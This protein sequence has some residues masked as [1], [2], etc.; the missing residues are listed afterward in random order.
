MTQAPL[1]SAVI[2]T[3]FRPHLVCRA[4]RSA[5]AQTMANLEV[6]V[7]VDGPDPETVAALKE[8]HDERLRVIALECNEGGSEARNIAVRQAH[9]EWIALLDDDDEWYPTKVEKQLA[10]AE[11]M[12]K[13]RTVVTCQ[14][15]DFQGSSN[16]LRPRRFPK[17]N[18][19]ISDFL[20]SEVSLLG[21]IEG[22]PQTST[23]LVSREFLLEVPFAKGLK[24]NQD[25][26]WLL[27]AL[28]LPDVS[29]ALVD[30][31][32][33]IFY[34]EKKRVRI[35]Q[36]LDWRDS[37]QW[38]MGNRNLFTPRALSSFL[39]VMCMNHAGKHGIQ[40]GVFCTLLKDCRRYGR[41]T[42]KVLWLLVLY[43]LVYPKMRA[44]ISSERRTALLY[45]SSAPGA[46]G[47]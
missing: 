27:R 45:H 19:A 7:V 46:S 16:L 38:A 22:F 37:Y 5:L 42:P 20:Y 44:F 10:V 26:D 6:I 34:N 13:G 30:E 9:S 33:S 17:P 3:R 41:V 35:T 15:F 4:V 24:R 31:P 2:P 28:R 14:Y 23:W 18:Q 39:A 25:T 11:G 40:W 1:V 29:M 21:T 8:F 36:A 12:P 43:G 47:D 32:L